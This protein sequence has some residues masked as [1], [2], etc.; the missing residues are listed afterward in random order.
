[1]QQVPA[2]FEYSAV[3]DIVRFFSILKRYRR[4]IAYTIIVFTLSAALFSLASTPNK[5]YQANAT[6]LIGSAKGTPLASPDE[7]IDEITQDDI[8]A[9]KGDSL[10]SIILTT[11]NPLPAGEAKTL[12]QKALDTIITEHE[13]LYRE[14][15]RLYKQKTASLERQI[16]AKNRE[17]K[18]GEL[19]APILKARIDQ[20]P[21][22]S[23]YQLA[24]LQAYISLQERNDA[25]RLE[26]QGF[27]L[28]KFAYK[29]TAIKKLVEVNKLSSG[30]NLLVNIALGI[31]L[32]AIIG[33]IWSFASEWWKRN[34]QVLFP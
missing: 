24:L 18:E 16:Q 32:G 13:Q 10:N 2:N 30:T 26:I 5:G 11:Q 22:S 29:K 20:S 21:V 14:Q 27:E 12:L 15:E 1:M 8:H 17:L 6:L 19:Y 34:K 7:V 31:F 4:R 9:Q 25:L 33:V 28:E 23:P 3:I